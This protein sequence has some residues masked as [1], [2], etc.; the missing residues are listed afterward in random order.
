MYACMGRISCGFAFFV[1]AD[2]MFGV[3]SYLCVCVFRFTG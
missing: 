1:A 2:L 3:S